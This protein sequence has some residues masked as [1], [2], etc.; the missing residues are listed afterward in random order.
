M[1]RYNT[2][3]MPTRGLLFHAQSSGNEISETRPRPDFSITWD[4]L[5]YKQQK[6]LL[7]IHG[8]PENS[9]V[10]NPTIIAKIKNSL[11]K[12]D[13]LWRDGKVP[14]YVNFSVDAIVAFHTFMDT[15]PMI[16]QMIQKRNLSEAEKSL[17]G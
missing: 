3:G 7:V 9:N 5:N 13:N 8:I 4:D 17:L 6:F 16:H 10:C 12:D 1:A 2:L 15:M 11:N 14:G